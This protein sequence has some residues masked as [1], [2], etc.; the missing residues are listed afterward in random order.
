MPVEG[1][2]GGIIMDLSAVN[3]LTTT[4]LDSLLNIQPDSL[5]GVLTEK[6]EKAEGTLF[7]AFLNSAIDN[8][9][10]TNNYLS[11][12]ENEEIKF[13]LGETKNTHDLTIA[14]NKASAALQYT[15][16]VRDKLLEAYKEIMQIQI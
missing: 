10:T 11:D 13:S 6:K 4:S 1:E 12:M 16:A 3:G 9:N 14:L 15:V 7:E 5:T 8:I 2:Y